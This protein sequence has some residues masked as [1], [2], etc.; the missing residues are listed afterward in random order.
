MH[1]KSASVRSWSQTI[2]LTAALLFSASLLSFNL[3]R[4]Y[5]TNTKIGEFEIGAALEYIDRYHTQEIAD[6]QKISGILNGLA[7]VLGPHAAAYS[8]EELARRDEELYDM[9]VGVGVRLKIMDG[10]PVV[11]FP[12]HDTAAEKAGIQSRD[13]I[14]A[15]D[16]KSLKDADWNEIFELLRGEINTKVELTVRREGEPEPITITIVRAPV[17][18]TS[19]E[20]EQLLPDGETAY[21]H[22]TDFTSMTASDLEK[23]LMDL[24]SK[25][26]K[27]LVLDIRHNG[28]GLVSAAV[29]V[30]DLFMDE[31][32]VVTVKSGKKGKGE[33]SVYNCSDK[34]PF[35]N[36]PLAVLVDEY[37]ASASEI[38]AGAI[39][40]TAGDSSSETPLMARAA[41]SGPSRRGS[42]VSL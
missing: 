35:K 24:E 30:A 33:T 28:G 13:V 41:F 10:Y 6:E 17:P 37:S 21:L 7:S 29:A 4:Y 27:K 3:Y 14:I 16:G 11:V 9:F 39:K 36:L 38:F 12:I 15:A 8:P 18:T 26:M 2:I 25:G 40:A 1:G 23:A 31:G 34:T 32:P 22:I 5:R 20:Y 42:E 19:I